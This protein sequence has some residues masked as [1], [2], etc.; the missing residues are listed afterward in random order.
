MTNL[1]PLPEK[2]QGAQERCFS[3]SSSG[4]EFSSPLFQASRLFC[5]SVA[6][7]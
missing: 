3:Q 7:L 2:R 6:T 5:F 1:C 4:R